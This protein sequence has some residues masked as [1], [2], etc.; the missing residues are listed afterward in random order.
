M[1]HSDMLKDADLERNCRRLGTTALHVLVAV[2]AKVRVMEMN[3]MNRMVREMT[4]VMAMAES[5]DPTQ[6]CSRE[7][8]HT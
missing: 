2:V 7:S 6:P 8:V 3:R 5:C 1:Y 4:T